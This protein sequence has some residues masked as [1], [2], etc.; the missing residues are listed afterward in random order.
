MLLIRKIY[1]EVHMALW[2]V[3]AACVLWFLLVAVPKLPEA[4]ARADALRVHEINEEQDSFCGQLG[5]GAETP[6]Y[7]QCLSRLQEYRARIERR[8]ADENQF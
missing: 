4:R 5:M 8:I 6:G 3:L 1:D 7:R 2:A